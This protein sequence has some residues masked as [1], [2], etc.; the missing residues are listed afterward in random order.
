MK[1]VCGA[2]GLRDCKVCA[3]IWWAG[4][5]HACA[6]SLGNSAADD[7]SMLWDVVDVHPAS[8]EE[9]ALHSS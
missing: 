8:R 9:P 5:P 6:P 1:L 4:H 2:Q 7:R 3:L